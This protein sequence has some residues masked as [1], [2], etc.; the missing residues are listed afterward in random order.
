MDNSRYSP[1]KARVADENE[2][3]RSDAEITRREHLR[4]EI[5]LKSVGNLYLFGATMMILA[6][7]AIVYFA[8]TR[9]TPR[10]DEI[11]FFIFY[12]VLAAISVAMGLGFRRLRPW[13]KIPGTILS[14]IGLLGFPLGTLI[15]SWILYQIH[16]EKGRVVLAPT[17][18]AIIDATPH[19]KY[20]RK[21]GEK[22][23][24]WG[25]VVLV[26]V[27]AAAILAAISR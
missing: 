13:V 1:P 19:V 24:A 2:L 11:A 20:E 16:G 17:Y 9:N 18:Q 22:I 3:N 10:G 25:L 15:N 27:G 14:V 21:L 5:Q 12:S 7:G 26:A 8:A 23:A 6:L 4:T